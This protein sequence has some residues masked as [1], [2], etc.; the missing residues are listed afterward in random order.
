M[1]LFHSFE[2]SDNSPALS[3]RCFVVIAALAHAFGL[4]SHVSAGND[5]RNNFVWEPR[6]TSV[7]VFKNGLGFFMREGEVELNDGWCAAKQIPPATFGTFA[8][9]AHSPDQLVDIVGSGTG[10]TIEFDDK[11]KPNTYL[12]RYER[13]EAMRNLSLVLTYRRHGKDSVA[14]G[15]LVSVGDEFAVLESDSGMSVVPID[16]LTRIQVADLPLRVHVSSEESQA[17]SKSKL[18]MAYL[19]KGITWIPEYTL[20]VLDDETAE[21]TL[22]GTLVNDAEDLI[23]TDVNFV[24]G[25]PHFVHT[26]FLSPLAIGQALRTIG[27]AVAPP[28]FMSQV[29]SRA[30]ITSNQIAVD[31]FEIPNAAR[32]EMP[33]RGSMSDP[34]A[35]KLPDI[36]ESTAADMTVY[37]V[38]NLTVRRGEKAM[39]TLFKQRIKYSHFYRWSP[40]QKPEHFLLLANSSDH[41]WTT[42]PCL[43][44][45]GN[46]PMS[47]DMLRYT[48]VNA[49]CDIEVTT[50]VNLAHDRKE[51][52]VERQKKAHQP[53]NN[54]YFLDRVVLKGDLK[55]R[56]FEKTPVLVAIKVPVAGSPLTTSDDGDRWSDPDK[57]VLRERQ[58]SV[59]WELKLEPG[60]TKT[61]EYTYERYVPSN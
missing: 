31:Q 58:G 16:G 22:R 54:L 17:A 41:A 11:D 14:S 32:E 7:S 29:M 24:V 26:D 23:H 9:Y 61:L 25:V 59:A 33:D 13:L 15:R 51:A 42:G 55:I 44:L 38:R 60:E 52:E 27:T 19:R 8:I 3:L 28:E 6:T 21:L 10:E 48:P 57:L 4:A 39:V 12:A 36:G 18:G 20:R 50:A 34:M 45:H 35:G 47:E 40:P 56:S 53:H 37:T 30:A 5:D 49:R 2:R 1:R 46:Q 43:T